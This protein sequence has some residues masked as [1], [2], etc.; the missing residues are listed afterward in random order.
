MRVASLLAW[1]VGGYPWGREVGYTLFTPPRSL[2]GD[3]SA[4]HAAVPFSSLRTAPLYLMLL[5]LDVLGLHD[6]SR[7]C[8]SP[9]SASFFRLPQLR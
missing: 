2:V 9:F 1:A 8:P 3:G 5:I 7:S 4:L 6:A